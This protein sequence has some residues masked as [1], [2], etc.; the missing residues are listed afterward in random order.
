[1][2]IKQYVFIARPSEFIQGS[3]G[4]FYMSDN[5]HMEGFDNGYIF[6]GQ[7]EIEVN[8]N[9][10]SIRQAVL[11][12]LDESESELRA[13]FEMSLREIDEKRQSLL[14]IEHKK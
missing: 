2:K 3:M 4:C 14:A 10:D 11:A 13:K 12:S 6:V 5:M 9:E 7:I 1:M 8:I